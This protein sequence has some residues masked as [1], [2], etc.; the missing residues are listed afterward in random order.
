MYSYIMHAN[1]CPN[2]KS[3][4]ITHIGVSFPVD[5]GQRT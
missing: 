2:N 4:F 3:I 1:T 5:R